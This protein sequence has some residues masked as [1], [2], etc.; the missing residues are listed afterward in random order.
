MLLKQNESYFGNM[1][2]S[3]CPEDTPVTWWFVPAVVM[4]HLLALLSGSSVSAR[5]RSPSS[6]VSGELSSVGVMDR[7]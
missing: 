3:L 7:D 1:N 4:V 6:V 2:K 5:C